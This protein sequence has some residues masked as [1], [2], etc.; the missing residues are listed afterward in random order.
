[1]IF[2]KKDMMV[3]CVG[4][5]MVLSA[6]MVIMPNQVLAQGAT[7]KKIK[8]GVVGPMK[9]IVGEHTWYGAQLAAEEINTA[10]GVRISG[11]KH[12]IELIRA[13]TNEFQSIPDA[14]STFETIITVDKVNFLV[15]GFRTE[16]CLAQQEVMADH[17][18]IRKLRR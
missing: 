3:C 14:V 11:V 1:M 16:A 8:I 15:G 17:K 13:D 2:R 18:V 6:L 9:F 12:E 10:G 5:L 7:L 4:F